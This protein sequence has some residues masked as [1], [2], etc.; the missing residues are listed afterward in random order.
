MSI[1]PTMI[2]PRYLS[3]MYEA[4][5]VHE[6]EDDNMSDSF[7]KRCRNLMTEFQQRALMSITPSIEALWNCPRKD[8]YDF[9]SLFK[10]HT[11]RARYTKDIRTQRARYTK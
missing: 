2:V 11:K 6:I 7:Y 1:T 9:A 3:I 5:E 8:N 10:C 4:S